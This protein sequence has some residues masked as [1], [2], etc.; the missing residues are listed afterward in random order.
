MIF[1][2]GPMSN[3]KVILAIDD[4]SMNLRTIRVVLE[5]DYDV[6]LAKSGELAFSMMKST[7]VDL[8]LL[9]IEMPGMSGFD[10]LD[11]IQAEK[12]ELM[13]IPVIFVTSNTSMDFIL[14]AT[15]YH[16]KDY[17]KK[18]IRPDLLEKKVRDAL[19]N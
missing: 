1:Q 12:P 3:K 19:V 7:K 6:R 13:D 14:K 5:K 18:P 17:I 11:K 16:A 2:E 8:I 9:D 10:F 15:S 4:V